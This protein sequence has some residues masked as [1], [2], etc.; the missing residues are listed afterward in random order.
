MHAGERNTPIWLFSF[1]DLTLL[2][3]IAFTQISRQQGGE[4]LRDRIVSVIELPVLER[5]PQTTEPA[6]KAALWQLR[7]LPRAGDAIE[8]PY[9]L[10]A[11]AQ[12]TGAT[13]SVDRSLESGRLREALAA[14]R[15]AREG[16]PLL[17][18]HRD[19]RS[20]DL[21]IAVALLEELWGDGRSA[22]VL[23]LPAV[24]SAPPARVGHDPSQRE[25]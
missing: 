3:L 8:A 20:E 24:S 4:E 10:A 1:V 5:G 22:T 23:G 16:K 25:R 11:G 15:E 13:E 2:L 7:V 21:L 9:V 18:P 17:L 6:E 14:I 19:S 12:E